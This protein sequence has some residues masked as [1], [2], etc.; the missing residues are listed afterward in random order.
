LVDGGFV[1]GGVRILARSG[2]AFDAV[3]ESNTIRQT[4]EIAELVNWLRPLP[5]L[6][7]IL[8]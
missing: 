8:I 7:N 3:D 2:K 1:G 5:M 6:Q 4:Y